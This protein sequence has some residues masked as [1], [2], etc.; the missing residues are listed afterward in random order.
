MKDKY[1]WLESLLIKVF[2]NGVDS[3]S[4]VG[5]LEPWDIIGAVEAKSIIISQIEIE[6]LR[7][8][9]E[10]LIAIRNIL[11]LPSTKNKDWLPYINDRIADLTEKL[12]ELEGK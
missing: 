11:L 5:A 8:T 1:S 3:A 6:K 12:K 2:N 7:A 9:I 4:E 10:E